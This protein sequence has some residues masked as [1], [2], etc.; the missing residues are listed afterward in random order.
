[1]QKFLGQGSNK[2]HSCNQSYSS[3]NARSL[4]HYGHRRTPRASPLNV[5]S[6]DNP[7]LMSYFFSLFWFCFVLFFRAAPVAYATATATP[8]LS[9]ICELHLG[10]QQHRILN[11][12]SEAR[13]RT[14]NLMIPSRIHFHCTMRGTPDELFLYCS[15]AGGAPSA[16]M[17]LEV[18]RK[19]L[20]GSL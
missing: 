19:N 10:S 3:D 7:G 14:R 18:P 15:A 20:I 12:L 5:Q 17:S 11:L 13:D 2:H 4:T 8:D 6:L 9:H 16:L 1:M